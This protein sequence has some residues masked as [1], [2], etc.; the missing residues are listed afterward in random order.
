MAVAANQEYFMASTSTGRLIGLRLKA[1]R[2]LVVVR[3]T[4]SRKDWWASW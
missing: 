3:W 1:T 4:I 2:P